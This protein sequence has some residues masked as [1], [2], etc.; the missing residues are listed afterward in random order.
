MNEK[1]HGFNLVA[2]SGQLYALGGDDGDDEGTSVERYDPSRNE[3]NLLEE[4]LIQPRRYASAV[5]L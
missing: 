2:M 1:R 4:K 3:W 5:V